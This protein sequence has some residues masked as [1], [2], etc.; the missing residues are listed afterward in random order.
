MITKLKQ[1][2]GISFIILFAGMVIYLIDKTDGFV[3]FDRCGVD[4]P[5]CVGLRCINGYC[6]S[7]IPP[8]LP[9]T[10]LKIVP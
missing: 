8:V 5:S 10:T 9:M 6:K 3:D 7:D 4:L 1:L 2:S